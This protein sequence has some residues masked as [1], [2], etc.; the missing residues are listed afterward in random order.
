MFDT[1]HIPTFINNSD[2][3]R[4]RSHSEI[5]ADGAPTYHSVLY[6][7]YYYYIHLCAPIL[8]TTT[9]IDTVHS[10]CT[11]YTHTCTYTYM[12]I[13]IHVHTHT[14]TYTYM[15]ILIH[16]HTHT[17]TYVHTDEHTH[18]CTYMHT[19]VHAHTCAS[20]Y[21]YIYTHV[22]TQMLALVLLMVRSRA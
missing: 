3:S 2:V 22:Y 10:K 11:Y 16:V 7:I 4:K 15:C 6:S 5:I 17:C 12:Y 13:L 14:C 1:T 8:E 18:T 20:T 19:L 21:M 9:T